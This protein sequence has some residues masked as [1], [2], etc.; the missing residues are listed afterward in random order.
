M[1][2]GKKNLGRV[3]AHR[4]GRQV[5][6]EVSRCDERHRTVTAGVCHS[7]RCRKSQRALSFG[8]NVTGKGRGYAA[9][10]TMSNPYLFVEP[11]N[12]RFICAT[13]KTHADRSCEKSP[14]QKSGRNDCADDLGT[15]Y[16]ISGRRINLNAISV[17]KPS[18]YTRWTHSIATGSR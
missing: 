14:P 9:R 16:D 5:G 7:T 11:E 12:S 18:L 1:L 6:R 4:L 8:E 13:L 10:A 2:A 17:P 15:N 3:S